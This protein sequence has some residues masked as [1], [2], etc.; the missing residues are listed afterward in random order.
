[1]NSNAHPITQRS[2]MGLQGLGGSLAMAHRSPIS[3]IAAN[4]SHILT[5]GYDNKVILRDAATK[6]PIAVGWHEH[7]VNHV[8]LSQ[9]GR[10]GLSS[11]SDHTARV[12]DIPS[13]KLRSVLPDHDD[14]V[15]MAVFDTGADR[16]VTGS[17]D[18]AVRI[19]D[20]HGQ[21]LCELRG[22]EADVISVAWS[23]DGKSAISSSDDSTVRRWDP[24][25]GLQTQQ[26]DLGGIE[27]DTFVICGDGTII[28]GNDQG[29]I[30]IAAQERIVKLPAHD[31]GIK[32]LLWAE[33]RGLLVTVSYDGTV[34]VWR[35]NGGFQLDLLRCSRL[36]TV[37]WAR[38]VAF[39]GD[40]LVF[41]T[42]G[43][44]FAT[45]RIGTGEWDLSGVEDT[46]GINAV[47]LAG[48][49]VITVGDAG[50]VRSNGVPIS[51]PGSLCN[52][53]VSCDGAVLTGG[54][55]GELFDALSGRVIHKHRSPL[56][57]AAVHVVDGIAKVV[58]GAYT[59]EG[60][61]LSP[62]ADGQ[63]GLEQV[64]QLH[65]N[66][67]KGVAA[68]AGVLFSVGADGAAAFHRARDASLIR[69]IDNAHDKIANGCAALADGGFV[70]V[71]RDRVLRFWR[72]DGGL[73]EAIATP[74]THSVKCVA[75][76]ADGRH[77]ATAAYNGRIAVFDRCQR[78]WVVD[79][80]ATLA[81]ISS[82]V[83]SRGGFT[84]SSYDGE[85]Y[86]THP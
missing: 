12:W 37:V 29:E 84:A 9:C 79:H 14:D 10:Y 2:S 35:V 57:C 52:F 23:P 85:V 72:L 66:A 65:A 17:R 82:I 50:V 54:Q 75:A 34:K 13:L 16:I 56:N 58:V 11:S 64:V 42:F 55:T 62:R 32:R 26:I 86:V 51:N 19:F 41:G 30:A 63:L 59:G 22:H 6:A 47:C 69:K 36:P 53:L 77:V 83:S 43:S 61:V 1:M 67:V 20:R 27:T 45:F 46:N 81:G 8:S 24:E 44:S 39:R 78:A 76:S 80:R 21:L 68:C 3:G 38:A 60:L 4:D 25:T 73:D 40:C 18:R 15:E 74:H 31:A 71:S 33:A 49:R 5:G 28:A 7:L 48:D 70:S